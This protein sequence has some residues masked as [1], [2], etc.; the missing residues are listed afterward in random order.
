[1]R[2]NLAG[3]VLL[4]SAGALA[5]FGLLVGGG[6]LYAAGGGAARDT[7]VTQMLVNAILVV[8]LQIFIG[9]TGILS[10][11]HMGFA[12]VAGYAFALLAIAP[13]FKERSVPD[14]PFGLT[15]VQLG[16]APAVVVAVV[17]TLALGLVVGLGLIRS[18]AKSG[19]IAATMITLALL[20]VVHEVARN[21]ADLTNGRA[22]LTF[23]PG[24][25]LEDRTWIYVIL[26]A[27]ILIARLF[28]ETETGRLAQAAREDDLAAR[29]LGVNPSYPQLAALL[30]SVV[31]IA[32]GA[33][34]RAHVLGSM[35]PEFFFFSYTLL[36]LV[37]LIVG[38][39][40]GVT[41]ALLGVVVITVGN[42]LTRQLAADDVSVPG[43]DWLLQEGLSDIFLGGAMLLF[44]I[45]RPDGLLGDW[46]LDAPLRRLS[47]RG[48]RPERAQRPAPTPPAVTARLEVRDLTV[49][50]GGF[51][52]LG[53]SSIEV[54]ADEIV[55][56]IGPNGAGKTTL[57][58][59][60]TGIVAPTGGSFALDGRSLTG[61]QPHVIGRAGLS[62]TFQNL[63]LFPA[64]SV[65]ENVA[66]AALVARRH[67]AGRARPDPDELLAAAGLWDQRERRARE[68]DYGAARKLELA[69]AAAAAPAFLLLDEPTSGLGEAES[70][71]MIDHVRATARAIG[72]GVLVIDH[73]LHFITTI[74]DRIYVLD[75]GRVIAQGTPSEIRADPAVQVAYLGTSG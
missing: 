67:R 38:G 68:L 61:Q 69:R 47:R 25:S 36:T 15:D 20:F 21:Y 11:G 8:G 59:V 10:F 74:C 53:G 29:A 17:V 73:D 40:N 64:L 65:R 58:N 24:N 2:G 42:E 48:P 43:L 6:L 12:A 13:R 27:A 39:R 1:M 3:R 75:Q 9:N 44:M 33:S 23:G 51:R 4:P 18:G 57:V 26:L 19:A 50:F 52:A 72:A 35:T 34:L 55:G 46:E 41:G 60:V 54:G 56:L 28:R 32:V 66:V 14:A 49:L 62:R 16:V 5:V 45:L 22:G 37:M 70:A 31:V 30:L 71:A 7:L 63:R